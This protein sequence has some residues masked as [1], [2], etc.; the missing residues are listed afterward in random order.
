MRR[1]KSRLNSTK[2]RKS[3]KSSKALDKVSSVFKP[4]ISIKKLQNIRD[5]VK[6]EKQ[7]N[8]SSSPKHKVP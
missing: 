5:P 8:A 6:L 1:K 7:Q 2:S 3:S 4:D